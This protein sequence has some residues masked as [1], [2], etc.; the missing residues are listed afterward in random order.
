MKLKRLVGF[1][2]LKDLSAIAIFSPIQF[3]LSKCRIDV[4]NKCV[5]QTC[6][7]ANVMRGSMNG[8]QALLQK[9]VPQTVY[10]HCN[11]HRLNL[12]LV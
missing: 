9:K 4:N 6:D 11:N 3:D 2:S 5:A 10:I 8:V 1:T 12:V 7:G